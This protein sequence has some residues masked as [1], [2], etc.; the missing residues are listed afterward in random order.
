[1]KSPTKG[2][3][4]A[5]VF[6]L[7]QACG[8]RA[9]FPSGRGAPEPEPKAGYGDQPAE[10]VAGAVSSLGSEEESGGTFATMVEML[11]GRVPGLQIWEDPNGEISVRIRGNQSILFDNSPLLVVDGVTVPS[12]SF[13]ST[14]RSMDPRDVRNVQ[15][16]KDA[17]STSMYG[18]RGAHG[19]ILISLKRR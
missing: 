14:L 1:M 10:K 3:A 16:L 18:S 19:V 15:V 2:A 6:V 8:S 5:L 12:Y 7:F 9:T 4:L 17:G 13:S 11:R